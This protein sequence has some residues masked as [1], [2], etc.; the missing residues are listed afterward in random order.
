MASSLKRQIYN[1]CGL[2]QQ[3]G[4]IGYLPKEAWYV[5]HIL[6]AQSLEKQKIIRKFRSKT[7]SS[8]VQLHLIYTELHIYIRLIY[9]PRQRNNFYSFVLIILLSYISFNRLTF[10]LTFYTYISKIKLIA[11]K[12]F[13]IVFPKTN[14]VIIVSITNMNSSEVHIT[15][16]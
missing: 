7:I 13:C 1:C 2:K 3:N 15:R 6:Q 4:K 16:E 12:L 11:L 9:F 5:E 10:I 14:L 8:E